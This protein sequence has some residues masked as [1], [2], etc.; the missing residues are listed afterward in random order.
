MSRAGSGSLPRYILQRILL[1]MLV[2]GLFGLIALTIL[3]FV[4]AGRGSAQV[5]ARASK[6]SA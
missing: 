6:F 5:A 1:V 2:V 3:S 4:S